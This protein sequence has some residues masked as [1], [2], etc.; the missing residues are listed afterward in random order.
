MEMAMK[1]RSLCCL[2]LFALVLFP[3]A[4]VPAAQEGAG[5]AQPEISLTVSTH[6]GYLPL[7]LVVIGRILG[8]EPRDVQSCEVTKEFVGSEGPGT[9]WRS[10]ESHTCVSSIGEGGFP[11]TFTRKDVLTK[12]GTYSYRVLIRSK[13]GTKLSSIARDVKVVRSP[14][15]VSITKEGNH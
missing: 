8:M 9:P 4:P 5:P 11:E 6:H 13:D 10:K 12:P 14:F 1:T 7:D 3:E 15:G 2:A